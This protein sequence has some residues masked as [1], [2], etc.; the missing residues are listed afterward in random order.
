MKSY[1]VGL[2]RD[3]KMGP[4]IVEYLERIDDTLDP[5]GGR[6]LVH[7]SHHELVEGE[8][9][10][11]IVVIEFPHEGAA[12]AWYDSWAYQDI[13]PLRTENSTSTVVLL[14]GVA[15]GHRATDILADLVPALD[16]RTP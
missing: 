11:D 16:R 5:Y 1:A 12:Q 13:L 10:G 6:F 14:D 7:G 3:V 2:L 15:E 9:P 4:W 8:A